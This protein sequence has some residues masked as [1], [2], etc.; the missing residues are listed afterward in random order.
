M[1]SRWPDHGRRTPGAA[2]TAPEQGAGRAVRQ[3]EGVA[4][5][6]GIVAVAC[7]MDQ[8]REF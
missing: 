6:A 4:V 5:L 7:R 8:D 3:G 1:V 2:A